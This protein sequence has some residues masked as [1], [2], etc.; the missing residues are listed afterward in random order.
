MLRRFLAYGFV[1]WA[2]E[3]AFTGLSDSV[4]LRDRRLRGHSYLW[5]LPIY[6]AGGLLLERLHDGLA[7]RGAGRWGRALVYT[8]GIYGVEFGSASLL[9]R[10]IGDVPW[11]Y[12]SGINLRGYVRLDY[13]P[14]WYACGWLF[15]PLER[16]LRKLDRPARQRHRPRLSAPAAGAAS[17]RR[18]APSTAAPLLP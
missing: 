9:N 11:R 14:F 4:C 7:S 6:G 16:E 13:A 1:G 8:A 12:V 3:V 10:L 17:A 2:V 5:M 15:E 18:P